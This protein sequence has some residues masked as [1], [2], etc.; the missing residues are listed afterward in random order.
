QAALRR[1]ASA[2]DLVEWRIDYLT[3]LDLAD[4]ESIRRV[5]ASKRLPVIVTCRSTDEGGQRDVPPATRMRLLAELSR[6][7]ADYCDVEAAHYRELVEFHPDISH[8]IVS[9]HNFNETPPDLDRVYGEVTS[10]PAAVHKIVTQAIS[11]TDCIP[12]FR[13]LDRSSREGRPLIAI[14]M[15][16]PG[17]ITRVL[18][19]SRGSFLTYVS[20]E[21]GRESAAGQVTG[22]EMAG[23]Y[24]IRQITSATQVMGVIGNPVSHSA[25]PAMHN[26]GFASQNIDA[27]YLPLRV[28]DANPFFEGLLAR[29]RELDL[30]I[31]GLSVTIPH[32]TNVIPLLDDLDQTAAA[33]GAVNCVTV[34]PDGRLLGSN[35]DV[36]GAMS[37]L[38]RICGLHNADCAVI[39][40]GGAARAVI[41]GLLKRGARVTVFARDPA[42]AKQLSNALKVDVEP[43]SL[44]PESSASIVVNTTPVGMHGHREGESP[45]ASEALRGRAVAYDLVYNPVKTRFLEDA[46]AAG[47]KIISGIEMLAAQAS[48][49]FES[50]TG[51]RVPADTMREAALEWLRDSSSTG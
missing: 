43:L 36:E 31:R 48:L 30:G 14:A 1:A 28:D 13:V 26:A 4:V 42:K 12:I 46:R 45:V 15:G 16:E 3:D 6:S 29:T 21:R 40:A 9:Y 50:W 34:Q 7:G 22:A 35:T 39:G 33:A 20:L 2:A 32:K 24:R 8:L 49:Q 18:G 27:V 11:I 19:P 10:L 23:L 38:D 47:C 41:L 44:F 17:L 51:K 5:L 25:S 37:P